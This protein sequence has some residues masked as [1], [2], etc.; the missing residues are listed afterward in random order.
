MGNAR[1]QEANSAVG[2]DGEAH[3]DWLRASADH[4]D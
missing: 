3:D 1:V 4:N 2:E